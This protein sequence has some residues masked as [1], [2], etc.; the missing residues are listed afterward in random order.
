[1]W[2]YGLD[3]KFEFYDLFSSAFPIHDDGFLGALRLA[4][5]HKA[6]VLNWLNVGRVHYVATYA[7]GGS[8]VRGNPDKTS[9]VDTFVIIDDTDVKR[10]SRVEL[11]EKLRGKP[12]SI[13]WQENI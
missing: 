1:M 2:S 6:L 10:M 7:I 9:D 8:L 4:N 11:I 12:V 3:S 13:K 5:V